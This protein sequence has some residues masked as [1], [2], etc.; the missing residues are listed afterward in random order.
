MDIAKIPSDR[1]RIFDRDAAFLTDTAV[2]TTNISGIIIF[3]R[4]HYLDTFLSK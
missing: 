2:T 4:L 3:H 1:E